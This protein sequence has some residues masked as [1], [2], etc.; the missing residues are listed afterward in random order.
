MTFTRH[1]DNSIHEWIE[2]PGQQTLVEGIRKLN[3]NGLLEFHDDL[4]MDIKMNPS[5]G[6]SHTT[7]IA[8]KTCM[9][10]VQEFKRK[11]IQPTVASPLTAGDA[12]IGAMGGMIFADEFIKRFIK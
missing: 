9:R 2:T 4:Q 11:G 7:K 8:F 10:M 5:V 1:F 6:N 3:A 12:M